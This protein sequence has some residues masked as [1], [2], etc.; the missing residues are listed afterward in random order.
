MRVARAA[1]KSQR[2]ADV[3]GRLREARV[4]IDG[5]LRLNERTLPRH[6]SLR[7]AIEDRDVEADRVVFGGVVEAKNPVDRIVAGRFQIEFVARALVARIIRAVVLIGRSGGEA[8]GHLHA[9]VLIEIA[10]AVELR[11]ARDIAQGHR[12][13]DVPIDATSQR[14]RR[15]IE[16]RRGVGEDRP[17]VLPRSRMLHQVCIGRAAIAEIFEREIPADRLARIPQRADARGGLILRAVLRPARH[18][19]VRIDRLERFRR[20]ARADVCGALAFH[21]WQLTVWI[22]KVDVTVVLFVCDRDTERERIAERH[23]HR[24]ACADVVV[25]ADFEFAVA[26]VAAELG[27][28]GLE[29]HRTDGGVAA[30][31]CALRSAQH[32][33][34]I[35]VEQ[36][37]RRRFRARRVHAVDEQR[38]LGIGVFGLRAV[39]ADAAQGQRDHAVIALRRRGES[40]HQLGDVGDVGNAL[41]VEHVRADGRDRDRGLLQRRLSFG[42][43]DLDCV[44]RLRLGV[45]GVFRGGRRIISGDGL[46]RCEY[47]DDRAGKRARAEIHPSLLGASGRD[48]GFWTDRLARMRSENYCKLAALSI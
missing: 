30:P 12:R 38:D 46:A 39:V 36:K 5:F 35:D 24:C 42:R 3:P 9:A 27:F 1:R 29:I 37:A 45:L 10:G 23:I 31:Q 25:V 16:L 44:E 22:L 41:L 33:D 18:V 21:R 15:A 48:A 8:R 17:E 6:R 13:V 4:R 32:F 11:P 2:I 20:A 26:V 47:G 34:R 19:D 14:I 7:R 28:G 43:R 40:R